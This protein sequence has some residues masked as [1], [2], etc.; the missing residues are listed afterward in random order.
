MVSP[1]TPRPSATGT[2]PPRPRFGRDRRREL[3]DGVGHPAAAARAGSATGGSLVPCPT[4]RSSTLDPVAQ[5]RRLLRERLV[6]V[7]E[8][9][10][11]SAQLHADDQQHEHAEEEDQVDRRR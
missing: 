3:L 6:L 1:K 7:L 8:A 2:N 11:L 4:W 9:A 10:D 5:Q